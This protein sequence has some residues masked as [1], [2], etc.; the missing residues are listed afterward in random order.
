MTA[1]KLVVECGSFHLDK[2]VLIQAKNRQ[3]KQWGKETD[4]RCK[5]EL[6][7]IV[8]CHKADILL[9]RNNTSDPSKWRTSGDLLA[10]LRLLKR[11]NDPAM[12]TKRANLE[13]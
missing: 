8:D 6:K 13:L 10:C 7:H 1:G 12:P 5:D 9:S 11:N 4:Q 3:I 2:N